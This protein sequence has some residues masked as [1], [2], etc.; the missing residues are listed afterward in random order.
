MTSAAAVNNF[1]FRY[2]K[3]GVHLMGAAVSHSFNNSYF[4]LSDIGM[5]K[6][7]TPL[8]GGTF[9]GTYTIDCIGIENS[10]A[11]DSSWALNSGSTPVTPGWPANDNS[12]TPE[13][14]GFAAINST[15]S[16]TSVNAGNSLN[17]Y[18]D[19]R[20]GDPNFKI[21]IYRLG[22]YNN[23]GAR[24]MKWYDSGSGASVT[25]LI[26]AG[27]KQK[28]PARDNTTGLID[29]LATVVNGASQNPWTSSY[30][31]TV[32]S[33]WLSGVYLA[34]LT[35]IPAS[36]TGKASYII[37]TVR[38]DSRSSDLY[39]QSSVTTWQAYNPWG[40]DSLYPYPRSVAC[41]V[42]SV[43]NGLSIGTAVSF[44]RPYAGCTCDSSLS[45]GSGA[46]EFLTQLNQDPEPGWEYNILRWMEKQGYDATY[47]T[48]VDTH[49]GWPV[50]KTTKA[51]LSVG[52]DEYWSSR[53]RSNVEDKR[54][55]TSNP[56]N[57]A[58]FASNVCSWQIHFNGTSSF[59]CDKSGYPGLGYPGKDLWRNPYLINNH[60][61]GMLGVE[62]MFNT[63]PGRLADQYA[64]K[65][66]SFSTHWVFTYSAAYNAAT[67]TSLTG[68]LGYEVDGVWSGTPPSCAF[69]PYP[70][71]RSGAS[72]LANSDFT[73]CTG[74]T[75]NSY[76][77]IYSASSG[78]KVFA[79]GTMQWSWGLDSYGYSSPS[80]Y[81]TSYTSD[82][83]RQV[84][85]NVLQTFAG[86]S[87]RHL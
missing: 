42:N 8:T 62:Y 43:P 73:P 38:E 2:A 37:F 48:S 83:A 41:P 40:G 78:A 1:W 79:T 74:A 59:S 70:T 18:V 9:S 22:W 72:T 17:L 13:I 36:G 53:Q 56:V 31:L 26:K 63:L 65:I 75:G 55:N 34:K 86:K 52:H 5:C 82:I 15:T 77:T 61:S 58:F 21:E 84:T 32:P 27:V 24:K 60:E 87:L 10:W 20:N 68:L 14:E 35:T 69:S 3:K 7:A 23:V 49:L 80:V 47:C 4:E 76:M 46:G 29:C 33:S 12:T 19:V 54:D 64:V 11:G 85:D 66:P 51:F 25:S 16:G 44:N 39:V 71:M 57:L 6:V 28:V 67:V 50:S 30:T 81:N 45:Y